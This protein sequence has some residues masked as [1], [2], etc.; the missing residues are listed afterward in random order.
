MGRLRALFYSLTIVS[1]TIACQRDVSTEP[2]GLAQR[3]MS[4]LQRVDYAAAANLLYEPATY[5]PEQLARERQQL[6]E[7]LAYLGGEFGPPT[8]PRV[9][10]PQTAFYKL[11]IAGADMPYWKS[12]PN[13]GIDHVL[14]YQV[15]FARVGSGVLAFTFIRA[16]GRWEV[17]SMEFG[18]IPDAPQAR[19]TIVQIGRGLLRRISRFD[20]TT[21]TRLLDEMFPP[22]AGSQVR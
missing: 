3:A 5:G 8:D 2:A 6:T 18:L 10:D 17:R 11:S 19:T 13:L 12:L 4:L 14:V 22:S 16:T 20:Q 21:I 15:H 9:L 1:A 7:L